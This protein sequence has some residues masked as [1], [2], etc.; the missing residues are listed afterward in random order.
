MAPDLPE[1]LLGI[2]ADDSETQQTES[3]DGDD[4]E[5]RL[6]FVFIGLGEHRLA[7]PIDNVHTIAE[8]PGELT[9][10]PRSP[11]AIDGVTDLRGDI[12]VVI[13]PRVHFP[14]TEDRSEEERLLVLDR[15]TDRQ[16]AA[17]R[18]DEVMG[19]ETILERNVLDE[20][21]MQEHAVSGRAL[22]HPLVMAI[23]KQEREQERSSGSVID[24]ET[25]TD[26]AGDET[27][28]SVGSGGATALSSSQQSSDDGFG[29]VGETFELDDETEQQ[30]ETIERTQQIVVETTAV[31]DVDKL[32]L[33]SGHD[34]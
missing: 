10:V 25:A 33:A 22:D 32:L 12:T 13:D 24:T 9:R 16:S 15:P 27:A 18:V 14:A 2:H 26:E 3:D 20:S 19:V 30:V 21:T 29:T 11:P 31:V 4:E 23:V 17:I 1:K 8:I 5:P 7:I 6:R 28:I 34:E